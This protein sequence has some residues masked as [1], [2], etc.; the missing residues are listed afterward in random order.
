M[1]DIF[2]LV[3]IILILKLNVDPS[4]GMIV[5]NILYLEKLGTDVSRKNRNTWYGTRDGDDGPD[6]ASRIINN[7][8]IPRALI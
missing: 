8:C 7:N 5:L 6:V 2:V 1:W 4:Y 3:Y